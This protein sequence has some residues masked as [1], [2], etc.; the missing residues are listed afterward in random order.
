MSRIKT[1][2]ASKYLC[3]YGQPHNIVP[4]KEFS[5]VAY[6]LC[7]ICGKKFRWIKGKEGRINNRLY[8]KVHQRDFAQRMGRTKKLYEYLYINPYKKSG[9]IGAIAIAER[10]RGE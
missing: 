8:L 4:W 7:K 9:R 3:K 5:D 10:T 6:E 2:Y 1:I